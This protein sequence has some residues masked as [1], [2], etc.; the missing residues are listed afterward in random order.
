LELTIVSRI[1]NGLEAVSRKGL[2]E[3]GTTFLGETSFDAASFYWRRSSRV[4]VA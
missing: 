2:A 4:K 3:R 1:W